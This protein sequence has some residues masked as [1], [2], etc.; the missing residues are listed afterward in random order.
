MQLTRRLLWA[1]VVVGAL[2]VVSRGA[3]A[4][5]EPPSA[6]PAPQPAPAEPPPPPAEPPPAPA[7]APA[8][9]PSD[10]DVRASSEVSAYADTDH[11]F[12][13]TPTIAGSVS[14]PTA[15]WSVDGRYLV[16]VVSA[17]SVDIVSTASRAMGRGA[18]RGLGGGRVQAGHVRRAR[19][20]QRLERARLPVVDRRRRGDAG[21]LRQEH[22]DR[23]SATATG[24]T[25]A[26]GRGRR[27]RSSRARSIATASSSARTFVVNK[28][29]VASLVLDTILE[30][31]DPSKPYRYVPL[32]AP[33]TAVPRGASP[34]LVDA[35][36]PLRAP[37]RAAPALA[38]SLRRSQ[39]RASRTA[40]SPPRLRLDERLYADS[41]GLIATTTDAR[42]LVDLGRRVELGPHVRFHA[43]T[44]VNFWQRAYILRPG[45]DY[46]ALR[47]GDRELGPLLNLTGGG[48]F[49]SEL[50]RSE[51]PESWIL[52][53]DAE[54]DEHPV[55]RR[56]L[57]DEPPLRDRRP[58]PGGGAMTR[59]F[60]RSRAPSSVPVA[61]DPVHDERRSTPSAARPPAC[62]PARSTGPA[63]RASSATT[64]RSATRASSPSR[65]PCT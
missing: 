37:A 14:N 38:R 36:P 25:S 24:T 30:S 2:S 48:T 18:A 16:D 59:P 60:S 31:G 19:E 47:T 49:R 8:P 57:H 50:G 7:E 45:F 17:A 55:P 6:P 10:I 58:H 26:G 39:R 21:S 65:A 15:G 40:S 9:A 54:R 13:V 35:A 33:G 23:S 22:H 42:Y 29:T 64:A 61:C 43:Q 52:G 53:L 44:A 63:S 51:H 20:R 3:F 41:W 4:A 11:V 46:P 28:Q 1:V 34:E 5:D 27:S 12:V 56:H 62:A 32:F